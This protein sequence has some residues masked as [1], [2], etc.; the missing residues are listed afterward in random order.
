M[1]SKESARKLGVK[2][3]RKEGK[4]QHADTDHANRKQGPEDVYRVNDLVM[5]STANRRRDYTV[6]KS[7]Q[8]AKLFPRRDGPYRVVKVF[9]ET[10][11]YWLDVPNA[12]ANFCFTF[13]ASQLKRYVEN[14]QEL[15][16]GQEL[17]RDGPITLADE[18]KEH[19]IDRVLDEKKGRGGGWWYLVR[20]RGTRSCEEETGWEGRS[21]ILG[22][23]GISSGLDRD[24][25]W[26]P[27]SE[28]D[29]SGRSFSN[30]GH[31]AGRQ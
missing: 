26:A 18:S 16:P 3:V 4:I 22:L 8:S 19:M 10:S 27:C 6:A 31:R 13:H 21:V 20:W 7:G 24:R 15:F 2:M 17:A 28:I 12:P 23:H 14:D 29:E 11:T 30:Y 1:E 9:P 5:L 25:Q